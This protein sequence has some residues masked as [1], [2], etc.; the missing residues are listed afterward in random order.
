LQ[1]RPMRA[2]RCHERE[3]EK[4]FADAGEHT[5]KLNRRRRSASSISLIVKWLNWN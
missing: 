3:D 4:K 1:Q 2:E 5:C